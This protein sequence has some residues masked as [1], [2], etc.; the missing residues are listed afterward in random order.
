MVTEEQD[1]GVREEGTTAGAAH[2]AQGLEHLTE[3]LIAVAKGLAHCGRF[4]AVKVAGHVHRVE[5]QQ[6]DLG[7]IGL[8]QAPEQ[9]PNWSAIA[10]VGLDPQFLEHTVADDRAPRQDRLRPVP[11]PLED[12]EC[13]EPRL[14][15][16]IEKIGH[17][18]LPGIGLGE[19]T[20]HAVLLAV[21]GMHRIGHVRVA[22]RGVAAGEKLLHRG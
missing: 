7:R 20:H 8:V 5:D 14:L 19:V 2:G 13:R 3:Q 17:R 22:E 1:R 9:P 15:D 16:R 10:V 21:E 18:P 12:G 4:R 11:A 6:D